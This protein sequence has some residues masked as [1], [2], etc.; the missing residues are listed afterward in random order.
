[1]AI[2]L[3]LVVYLL[4]DRLI[5]HPLSL[6]DAE[7]SAVGK[8]HPAVREVFLRND[9]QKIHAWHVDAGRDAPLV[10]YFGGNAEDVSG[11]IAEV[12]EH[13]PGASWLL[14]S[15]RGYGGSEGAPSAAAITRDALAWHDHAVKEWK[16]KRVFAFGRSLGSGPAVQLAGAR[17]LA[18]V[19]L[20]APFDSLHAVA[21]RYYWYLPVD[22]LLKHRFDSI[23]LAPGI[24]APLLCLAVERDEVIP[25][26]HARRLYDAWAGP[27]QWVLLP[28]ASHGTTDSQPAFWQSIGP[29]LQ[30]S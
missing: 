23:E 16:P 30:K 25:P 15:Y 22:L 12:L 13:A 29:F 8:R 9:S 19:V 17:S 10:L 14:V 27:K 5:F 18:G 2:G 21:K 11:M 6:S 3:P 24:T 7:R 1:M 4:Q 28:G 20:V 26:E